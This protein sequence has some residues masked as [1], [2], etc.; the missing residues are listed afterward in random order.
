MIVRPATE[1]DIPAII[2]MSAAFYAGTSYAA[3]SDMDDT[4]VITIAGMAIETGTMLVAEVDGA[5]VGMVCLLVLP[6]LFNAKK[7][8]AEEVAW[9]VDPDAR[10]SGAGAA[11][12]A[13]I[14]PAC[15][16]A[17]ADMIRMA[18]LATSPSHAGILYERAG[19]VH[20]D[21]TYTKVL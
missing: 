2:G 5:L 12:L 20:S 7:T 8:S 10:S 14:E 19:Y 13:A 4:A 9:W 1:A 21:T 6:F 16:A 15:L 11:L 17:G 18:T 3:I